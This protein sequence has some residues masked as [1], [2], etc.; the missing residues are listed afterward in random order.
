MVEKKDITRL[1]FSISSLADL[2]QEV[3]SAKSF[4]D[5]MKTALYVVTGMFSVP[6]AALLVY[7]SNQQRL[8][9]LT[10]KGFKDTAWTNIHVKAKH[11]KSFSK[12]EPYSLS[13]IKTNSF[14]NPDTAALEKFHTKTFIPLFAKDEFVGAICL[15]KRLSRPSY[16][17]SEKNVLKVV[18]NHIAITLHNSSLF[19]RLTNKVNENKKLYEDMRHIYHDTIQ[20]F[21]AAIDAKDRYTRNHSYR[22]AKYAVAI[23]RELGWK[24]KDIET[25]DVAGLLHDIGKIIIDSG[26]INK[27]TKLSLSEMS[28][29]KRHPQVSYDILSKI[30]FPWRDLVHFVRHHHER[31][32]GMGYPDA[33]QGEELSDG[34]KILA[35]ADAFDAMTT[36][37]PYRRK[38]SLA[39]ALHEVKNCLGTQFD[40]RISNVFFRVLQK[41]INGETKKAQILP[42]FALDK[43]FD[44]TV[45]TTL[46]ETITAELSA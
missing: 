34:V 44:P 40:S 29:I 6:K 20:A 26:V 42:H 37:R 4:N 15:G 9:L 5:R 10:H 13:K 23:A 14:Y 33:L 27:G 45:I 16:L 8:E 3:T 35:I 18:A 24:E 31:M 19:R 7:N 28:E 17:Q 36:D 1:L 2:G 25:I 46:L 11:I 30:R 32:D 12:N 38:L 39:E 22:V 21:A 43:G 41:E